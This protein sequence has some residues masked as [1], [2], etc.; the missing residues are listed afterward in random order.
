[1]LNCCWLDGRDET[2]KDDDDGR[3]IRRRVVMMT[4]DEKRFAR[5][6]TKA[7]RT[8]GKS[9]EDIR[10]CIMSMKLFLF[11]YDGRKREYLICG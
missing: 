1:M 10:T 5:E 9:R 7:L 8:S 11:M 4:C 6:G 2:M 3:R